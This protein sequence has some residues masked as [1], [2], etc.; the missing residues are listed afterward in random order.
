MRG[1]PVRHLAA[2]LLLIT[3]AAAAVSA[4]LHFQIDEILAAVPGY[5]MVGVGRTDGG[6]GGEYVAIL[7]RASRLSV[8]QTSTFWL[9]DTPE[10]VRP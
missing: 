1:L 8:R 4:A 7:Y 6:Q 3:A 5:R 9:S 10:V 2:V